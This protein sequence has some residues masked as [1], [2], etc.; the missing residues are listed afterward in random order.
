V[1]IPSSLALGLSMLALAVTPGPGVF[2]TTSRALSSGMQSALVVIAGIVTGDVIY[3]LLAVFGLT[4]IASVLGELFI[5]VRIIGGLY[6]AWLGIRLWLKEPAASF[7]VAPTETP[8]STDY[9]SGLVI[10]LS[11]P[12]VILFY[13]GFLPTFMD[14]SAL[15]A[16]DVL[17]VLAIVAGVL[18]SVM[19]CY[20]LSATRVRG[21]ITTQRTAR[22]LDRVAGSAMIATGAMVLAPR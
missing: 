1:T 11:N 15:S 12:K 13:G 20:A 2:V 5:A 7:S 22:R 21:L 10:T 8:L 16:L 4:M 6:L 19:V 14:L 18:S 9:V 3:L 17:A